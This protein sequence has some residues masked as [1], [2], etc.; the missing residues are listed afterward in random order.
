VPTHQLGNIVMVSG[1]NYL[2][3]QLLLECEMKIVITE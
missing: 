3:G 1:K 2:D